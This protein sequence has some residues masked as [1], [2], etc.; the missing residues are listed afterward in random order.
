MAGYSWFLPTLTSL[1]NLN[2]GEGADTLQINYQYNDVRI[3]TSV[4]LTSI[5]N[6]TISS[7]NDYSVYADLSSENVKG[8]QSI[9]VTGAY[10]TNVTATDTTDVAISDAKHDVVVTG[11]N[12]V[13]ISSASGANGNIDVDGSHN[14]T[15][16]A[17]TKDQDVAIGDTDGVTGVVKVTHSNLGAGH[18]D[19]DGATDVTVT[20]AKVTGGEITIGD[21]TAVTG[22][23]SVTSTGADYVADSNN[24][25]ADISVKGGTSVTVNQ[26]AT[27][28]SAKAA[29]DKSAQVIYEGNIYVTGTSKTTTVTVNQSAAVDAVNARPA[30]EGVHE[31]QKVTFSDLTSGQFV[32][33]NGLTF[34]AAKDLT[35]EKVAAAFENLTE[36]ANHGSAPASNG[37]Y[38]GFFNG[39]AGSTG[40]VSDG[41]SVIFT[42][43]HGA[44]I[45]PI[46]GTNVQISTIEDGVSAV[47]AVTGVA[48]VVAGTINI[49]G[50][51]KGND[52]LANVTLNA[53]AASTVVGSDALTNLTLSN[54]DAGITVSNASAKTLALNLD[55]L[56]TGS[57]IDLD[58]NGANKTYT[59]LNITTSGDDSDV[60]LTAAAVTAL[61]VAG[62]H[63]VDLTG[64]ALDAL[65]TVTVTGSA[66]LTLDD[67]V[68]DTITAVNTSGTT[69]DVTAT[70]N[71]SKATYTGGAG[72]DAVTLSATTISKAVSLGAGDDSLTLNVGTTS[73]TA[74]LAGGDGTDTLVIDAVDAQDLSANSL[75]EAKISGFE[76][77]SL[78]QVETGSGD[79]T[80]DLSNLDN[81]DY[82]VS[83]G[84][85]EA[86]QGSFET[87]DITFSALSSGQSVTV[88]GIVVT[89]VDGDLTAT[90]VAQIFANGSVGSYN[91]TY[92]SLGADGLFTAGTVSGFNNDHV[93][94]TAVTARNVANIV[95]SDANAAPTTDPVVT[96]NTEYVAAQDETALVKFNGL[97]AGDSVTVDGRTVTATATYETAIASFN[98][99]NKG[100]TF[101]IGGLTVESIAGEATAN[102]IADAFINGKSN[103]SDLKVTGAVSG[104]KVA[105]GDLSYKAEFTSEVVGNVA[106]LKQTGTGLLVTPTLSITDGNLGNLTATEVANAFSTGTTTSTAVVT[107]AL[108]NFTAGSNTNNEITFTSTTTAQ[109]VKDIETSGT[110][111]SVTTTDGVAITY[112]SNLVTFSGLLSGQ[113]VAVAGLT[114]T[115]SKDLSAT[116]VANAFDNI[117]AGTIATNLGTNGVIS[118]GTFSGTLTDFASDNNTGDDQVTFTS[119]KI[120]DVAPTLESNLASLNNISVNTTD[121]V[122]GALTVT[123]LA[124]DGTLELTGAAI[125]T[126]V[127]MD[128]AT[129]SSD[130]LNV[131]TTVDANDINFGSVVVADVETVTITATDSSPLDTDTGDETNWSTLTLE[132]DAVESVVV[133]GNANLNLTAN[134][135]VLTSVDASLLTGNF[136]F[137]SNVEDAVVI[138]G[139][140]DDRLV[141]ADNGQTLTGGEGD[142]TLVVGGDLE[143]LTGGAG[144]DV[145][146]I[147][148]ATTN[149]NSYATIKDFTSGD[150]ILFQEDVIKFVTAKVTLGGTAVLQ[151]LANAAIAHTANGDVSWFQTGGNT[152]V[153]ENVNDG[154]S[155]LNGTDV[156]V[157]ITGLVDLSGAAFSSSEN[158]LYL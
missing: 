48:R 101:T 115:A 24:T 138:G 60:T 6:V 106:D 27:S 64:A 140:G 158:S 120:G 23:V 51:I 11:G 149:V 44:D 98:A 147:S 156:I 59:T 8:L 61:T 88:D 63:A 73:S 58:N 154:S 39:E 57:S 105:L 18:V 7:S 41:K 125:T 137:T 9:T 28:S 20:V 49:D 94:F 126:T 133:T 157:K 145:F 114:L 117:A 128:D 104:Y 108:T 85:A 102:D 5:E 16:T 12:D 1:D 76:K 111:Q 150:S 116:D 10:N 42:S 134:G 54:S 37:V 74:N 35:K 50:H 119:S 96:T 135:A 144:H 131:I 113:S 19:I 75:F 55:N 47:E 93:V 139:A 29:D 141:A 121:G 129:G 30:V 40:A 62:D 52:V 15:V 107:G 80:V 77:L 87:A 123:H 69:G 155:F 36:Y 4:K 146:D 38:T 142:D 70:I 112:E 56:G 17:A 136:D 151:D 148:D 130:S 13:T 25:L 68:V 152:Y 46:S 103:N 90:E 78:N 83:A 43:T 99:L 143:E 81:I 109:N 53:Y 84:A 3:P 82:V 14:V 72:V 33:V 21:T 71:A 79:F 110:L 45:S 91:A 34:T 118:G 153:V 89:A 124:N 86:E 31:T 2:G 132:N 127:E 32:T 26:V 95:T 22:A 66:G 92:D 97:M 65:K 122:E 67:N 100:E